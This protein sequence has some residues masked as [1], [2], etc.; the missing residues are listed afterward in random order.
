[1][2]LRDDKALFQDF[3]IENLYVDVVQGYLL[4]LMLRD[5]I[6]DRRFER[7]DLKFRRL[8][9]EETLNAH[10]NLSVGSNM[11]RQFLVV[12]VVE[13]SDQAFVNVVDAFTNFTLLKNH[14]TFGVFLRHEDAFQRI[15]L[16]VG[17]RAVLARQ[18][19]GNITRCVK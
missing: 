1:M 17:H 10:K 4:K 11:L 5:E 6:N 9:F 13:L 2:N 3:T 8:L 14:L 19:P 18:L 15:E 12:L 16:F 7:F